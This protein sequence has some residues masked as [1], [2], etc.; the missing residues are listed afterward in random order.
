M[1]C[2]HTFKLLK[3]IIENDNWSKYDIWR[4][5]ISKTGHSW[6]TAAYLQGFQNFSDEVA[7][8]DPDICKAVCDNPVGCSNI[9][10]PKLVLELLPIGMCVFY[11]V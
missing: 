6:L 10:Y 7:C 4:K 8:T 1:K 3:I 2:D 5:I 9:A 11:F